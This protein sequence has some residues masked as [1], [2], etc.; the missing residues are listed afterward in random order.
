MAADVEGEASP[1]S[2][3]AG[4]LRVALLHNIVSPHVLPLF[5]RLASQPGLAL[6]VYF[7]AETDRNRRWETTVARQ[8]HYEVLPHWA[9]RVGRRDLHTYFVNPTVIPTLLREGFDVVVSAGWDSFAAQAAFLLCKALRKPYVLWSGSTAHEPSWRRTVSLP[10]VKMMVRGAAGYVAYGT[11]AREYLVQLGAD[12]RRVAIAYNTVDV[13]WFQARADELRP[14]R[15]DIRR[16]LGLGTEPVV[17]YVGQMIERKGPHDLLAAFELVARAQP[18][19]QLLLVGY[20]PLEAALRRAAASRHLGGVTFAGHVPLADLPRYYV[21]ADCFVLP[22]R[23]EVW[24]LVLNE[25]AACSLPLVTTEPV[26][27]GADL[28]EPGVNGAI[29]PAGAPEALAAALVEVLEQQERMGEASRRI[30]GRA[31]YAQNV[32]AIAGLLLGLQAAAAR[33]HRGAYV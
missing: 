24:G 10:L 16:Q 22:S 20:G 14:G 3:P 18:D 23:E 13:E 8:L 29:V 12:P 21:A 25:A 30:V 28:I 33:G 7:L 1:Q 19:V 32:A 6:K 31:T 2:S 4:A 15:V 9:L 26:G 5:E 27:G 11:R 17:L